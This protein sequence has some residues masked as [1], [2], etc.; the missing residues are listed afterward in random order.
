MEVK[1]LVFCIVLDDL[2]TWRTRQGADREVSGEARWAAHRP[3][4]AMRSCSQARHACEAVKAPNGCE[5][6]VVEERPVD[7]RR[8]REKRIAT[9]IAT[10]A[11]YRDTPEH[12]SRG[13]ALHPERYVAQHAQCRDHG[14]AAQVSNCREDRVVCDE[15]VDV[16]CGRGC[17]VC[18]LGAAHASACVWI[19]AARLARL[20]GERRGGSSAHV[21]L[22]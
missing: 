10:L 18:T 13:R 5:L 9:A 12:V 17:S 15:P 19:D 6:R 1:T 14:K 16:A 3:A 4:R 2:W 11:R 7:A 22:T 20:R 8:Q 21:Q